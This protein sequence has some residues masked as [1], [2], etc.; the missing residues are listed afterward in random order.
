MTGPRKFTEGK[1]ALAHRGPMSMTSQH[2]ETIRFKALR[3]R[4]LA[5]SASDAEVAEELRRIAAEIDAA[6][7]VLGTER[8]EEA[9][10]P[11]AVP[12]KHPA[13]EGTN[14]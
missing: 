14:A 3:C 13:R 5:E 4:E 6:I 1:A 2:I 11:E 9:W 12:N 10:N 7:A 8:T